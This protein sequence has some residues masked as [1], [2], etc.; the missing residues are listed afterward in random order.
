MKNL[1]RKFKERFDNFVVNHT[2]IAGFIIGFVFGL[3]EMIVQGFLIIGLKKVLIGDYTNIPVFATYGLIGLI[4]VIVTLIITGG[5]IKSIE[6]LSWYSYSIQYGSIWK[7]YDEALKN[8]KNEE[9]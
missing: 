8:L 6:K 9:E 2:N 1:M 4:S 5:A 3:L 7:L